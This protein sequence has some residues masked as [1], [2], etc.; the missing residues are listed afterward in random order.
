[1]KKWSVSIA[2]FCCVS[3]SANAVNDVTTYRCT[4]KDAVSVEE[5]GTLS[6]TFGEI[7]RK[8]FDGIVIDIKSGDVTIPSGGI[9]ETRVV[10]KTSVDNDFVLIPSY[11]LQRKKTGANAAT[12][13]IR[14]HTAGGKPHFIAFSLSYLVSGTCEIVR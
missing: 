13:F 9:R 8:Y 14:L 4:A 7:R 5:D 3:G 10:Q 11:M 2:F 12:D 1:M 6:K